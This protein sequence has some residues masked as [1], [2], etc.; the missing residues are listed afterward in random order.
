M[1]PVLLV[2]A[3]GL[4]SRFGGIKQLEAVG[5]N[6]ECLLDYSTYDAFESGYDKVIYIIRKDI[7]KDF[8]DRLFDK[9]KSKYGDKVD[10]TF[11]EQNSLLTDEQK[12]ISK[13]RTKPWGTLHAI[14]C[15]KEKIGDSPFAVINADDFYGREAL[16]ILSNYLNTNP[17][18]H[19]M[20]GYKL[21]NTMSKNGSVSR[22]IC[23]VNN[24][25][26][27]SIEENKNI[28][29]EGK[30]I[31]TENQDKVELTGEEFVSM[32][33]FGFTPKIF[34]FFENY[35]K[36]FINN[37]IQEM[38]AECLIPIAIGDMLNKNQG[39]VKFFTTNE[40]WF[41][42]TYSADKQVVKEEIEKKIKEGI[43]PEML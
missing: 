38:K 27:K 3:A 26:L 9:L 43:Y 21:G 18:E 5:K 4:G 8:K 31:I 42:M 41:G 35:W 12:T 14:L 34:E 33:F 36:D 11:Q 32:N 25:Y 20:V 37:N 28:Y 23:T 1:K 16:K 15:A 29:Y 19:S 22:G 24:G 13:S 2:L 10:Y 6:N 30:K 39:K 17:T 7:E 40:T